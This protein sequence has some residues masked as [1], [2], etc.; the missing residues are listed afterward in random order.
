METS[1]RIPEPRTFARF[2]ALPENRA[3]LLAAR[4]VAERPSV[5]SPLFLHGPPGSGKSHLAAAL[6]DEATQR[7]PGLAIA[8]L[9]AGDLET[10]VRPEEDDDF[11][12]LDVVRQ[13]DLL[14]V[15]DVQ[16]VTARTDAALVRLFDYF[17]ARRKQMVFTAAVGPRLLEHLSARLTSRLAG[18]LV[19]GLEAWAA[20]SRLTLLQ[21]KLKRKQITVR[22]DV[23]AWLAG[24]LTGGGRQLDGAVARLE[25]LARL[26]GKLDLATVT[27]N[28]R[29]QADAARPSVERI[30]ERVGVAFRVAPK[31]LCSACRHPGVLLPRQV[32][33]YLVRRLTDLS[34][35]QIGA[36]FGGRDHSTV[37]HACRKVED[38]L[39]RDAALSGAVRQLHADLA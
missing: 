12:P 21:D 16:H 10:L 11:D 14:L 29:E 35:G 27:A 20:P 24:Q 28:F 39:N 34:L 8:A 37:L 31:E 15:E 6:I 7:R 38:A 2:V 23:L 19:V 9:A 1:S 17:H 25:T 32:G 30:V 22:R 5:D 36:Y 4:Q 18:G 33:M 13:A 3:A 26:H